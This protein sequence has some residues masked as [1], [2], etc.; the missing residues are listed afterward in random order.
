MRGLL[1]ATVLGISVLGDQT[2]VRELMTGLTSNDAVVRAKAA[3]ELKDQGDRA[4]GT[5]CEFSP[6]TFVTH[7]FRHVRAAQRSA[8]SQGDLEPMP[9]S[10]KG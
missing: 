3:C 6:S 8:R 1:F 10:V 9:A 2:P 7:R 4:S 5:S